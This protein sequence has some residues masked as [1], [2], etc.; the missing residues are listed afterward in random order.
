MARILENGITLVHFYSRN[1]YDKE[2]CFFFF[3][4]L[5]MISREI[6]VK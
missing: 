4:F 3:F 1:K 6:I 5:I 2:D